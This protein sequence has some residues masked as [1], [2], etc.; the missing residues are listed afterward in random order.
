ML[1]TYLVMSMARGILSRL[2][3][4]TMHPTSYLL[5]V[6]VEEQPV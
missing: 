6:L 3:M 5:Q 1:L 2:L 4:E